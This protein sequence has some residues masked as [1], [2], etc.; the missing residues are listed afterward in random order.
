MRGSAV[1]CLSMVLFASA[2]RAN[3]ACTAWTRC[4]HTLAVRQSPAGLAID[5]TRVYW[6]DHATR[7]IVSE[8]KCGGSLMVIASNEPGAI[9]DGVTVTDVYWHTSGRLARASLGGG[10]VNTVAG[11]EVR[12]V[13]VRPPE[14]L[15]RGWGWT[16]VAGEFL[17][18]GWH[19][20]SNPLAVTP[21]T[22]LEPVPS[23]IALGTNGAMFGVSSDGIV[24]ASGVVLAS[25]QGV[26][27]IAADDR[28]VFV[29][30]GHNV[31]RARADGSDEALVIANQQDASGG[32]FAD[33]QRVY[34]TNPEMGVVCSYPRDGGYIS[35]I[36]FAEAPRAIVTDADSVY[37]TTAHTIEKLTPK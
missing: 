28:Y 36:A 6:A 23:L 5:G 7:T 9:V 20:L 2:A 17:D 29:R 19:R 16:P 22:Q 11:D 32:L 3:V 30:A 27:A 34:W 14:V 13:I 37:F 35:A 1:L 10:G 21:W 8:P 26:F 25:L 33:G 31:L 24:R 12:A 18:V 4:V 15:W